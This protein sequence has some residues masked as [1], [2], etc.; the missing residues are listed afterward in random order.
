MIAKRCALTL[1]QHVDPGTRRG[2]HDAGAKAID[3]ILFPFLPQEG[4]RSIR[5]LDE[6]LR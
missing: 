6:A 2:A 1:C 5:R 4:C 3:S